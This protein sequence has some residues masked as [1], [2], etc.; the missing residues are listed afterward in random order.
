MTTIGLLDIWSQVLCESRVVVAEARGQFAFRSRCQTTGE[1]TADR[2]DSLRTVVNC[3]MF[4][5]AI[6][7]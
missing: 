3:R 5:L 7:P 6:A 1:E 2:E 4:E